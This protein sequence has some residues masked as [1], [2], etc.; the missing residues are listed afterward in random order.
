MSDSEICRIWEELD[1]LKNRI[2]N[3][4]PKRSIPPPNEGNLHCFFYQ[5]GKLSVGENKTQ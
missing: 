4:T 3:L 5:K 1:Y 2:K